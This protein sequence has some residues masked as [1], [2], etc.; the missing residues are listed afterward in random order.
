MFN[1]TLLVIFCLLSFSLVAQEATPLLQD[2]DLQRNELN[3][4]GMTVLASWSIANIAWSV[5]QLSQ[6]NTLKQ[7]YHQMNLGWNAVNLVIAGFGLYQAYN[8]ELGLSFWQSLDEQ[9]KIKRILAV[10]AALDLAYIAGGFYLKEYAKSSSNFNQY[11]GFGRAVI[12]NGAF[13]F[14]FDVLMY[15]VHQNH[16]NSILVPLLES[17]NMGPNGIGLQIRF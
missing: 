9:A 17:L 14:G 2:F 12:V 7:S 10:N 16:E 11:E 5:S 3:R 4:K 6:S 15:W 1:R 13:L 8:P